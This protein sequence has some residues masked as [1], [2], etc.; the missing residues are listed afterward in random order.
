MIQF[1]IGSLSNEWMRKWSERAISANRKRGWG[2][3]RNSRQ[4]IWP[5]VLKNIEYFSH[6]DTVVLSHSMEIHIKN[7]LQFSSGWF[8]WMCVCVVQLKIESDG[9]E[10]V[11]EIDWRQQF[12]DFYMNWI[13][14]N[15]GFL[16]SFVNIHASFDQQAISESWSEFRNRFDC[17]N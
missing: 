4:E 15:Y 13:V 5:N 1:V 2:N 8:L 3:K 17:V 12:C 11:R 7:R 10:R 14:E 16:F 9:R 6:S